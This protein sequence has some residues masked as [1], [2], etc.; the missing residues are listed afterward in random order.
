MEWLAIPLTR[1][2]SQTWDRT[3][4]SR[5]AGGFFTSWATREAQVYWS[6]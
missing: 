4:V 3:Q 6:G 2:S 5:I 1:E